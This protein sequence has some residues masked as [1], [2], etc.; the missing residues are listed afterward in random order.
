M[1]PVG[2][3]ET[4]SKRQ[5]GPSTLPSTA[6]GLEGFTRQDNENTTVQNASGPRF[7]S[8]PAGPKRFLDQPA[9]A[10][11]PNALNPPRPQPQPPSFS[12]P[13]QAVTPENHLVPGGVLASAHEDS[14]V[15]SQN[16]LLSRRHQRDFRARS[17][18]PFLT[19][20]DGEND[21]EQQAPVD[22]AVFQS[23]LV[24]Q[25]KKDKVVKEQVRL[26]DN[27]FAHMLIISSM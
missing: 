8:I 19:T 10:R 1:A 24:A 27:T 14:A 2:V 4:G 15:D 17:S 12:R 6:G 11:N 16:R 22:Y 25:S 3:Q 18:T 26:L 13:A 7:F 9:V 21:A 23:L 5:H 20:Q